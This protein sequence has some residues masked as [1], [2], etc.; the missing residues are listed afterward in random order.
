[1]RQLPKLT[2]SVR[3]GASA[4][5]ALRIETTNLRF[6]AISGMSKSA[7]LRVTA[8][9][10]EI[11][12]QWHVAIVDA[13]GM[14]QMNAQDANAIRVSEFHPVTVLD[15]DTV[16]FNGISSAGFTTY[17][18]GGYLAYYVPMDLTVYSAARMDVKER[19]GG[20]VKLAA[21]TV[22]GMLTLVAAEAKLRINLSAEN[23]A[24]LAAREYVFDVELIKAGG[25]DAI[26]S[27]DST[28]TVLPEVTTSS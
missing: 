6:A 15:A 5:I 3:L 10:H 2:L 16:D 12:D 4:D 8:P 24:A 9:N 14:T 27:A 28:L 26:C 7:P 21:N 25:I 23:I 18:S 17:S 11:L 13:N 22:N 19:V 20:E 1:M